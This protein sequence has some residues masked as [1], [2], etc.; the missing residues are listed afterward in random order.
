MFMPR[1]STYPREMALVSAVGLTRRLT[2]PFTSSAVVGA[3]IP[4]PTFPVPKLN[5]AF[6]LLVPGTWKYAE[7]D[8]VEPTFRA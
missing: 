7:V 8:A 5:Q 1:D 3:V 2:I 4:I 6:W